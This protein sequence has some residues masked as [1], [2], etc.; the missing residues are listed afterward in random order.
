MDQQ[1]LS[2]ALNS[3]KSYPAALEMYEYQKHSPNKYNIM[4]FY[5]DLDPFTI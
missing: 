3:E 2:K 4:F 5:N 1:T